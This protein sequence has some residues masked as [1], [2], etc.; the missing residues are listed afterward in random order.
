MMLEQWNLIATLTLARATCTRV[1]AL[2]VEGGGGGRTEDI[3]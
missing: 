3:H 2:N 1:W